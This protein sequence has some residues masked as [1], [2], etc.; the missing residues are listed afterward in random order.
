M[1]YAYNLRRAIHMIGTKSLI[2]RM[3]GRITSFSYLYYSK[4]MK[5]IG[6]AM[7]FMPEASTF[8]DKMWWN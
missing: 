6:V 3:P 8:S 4:N 7:L 5:S 1:A 2:E